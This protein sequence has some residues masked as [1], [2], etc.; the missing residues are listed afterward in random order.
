MNTN[1]KF[2]PNIIFFSLSRVSIENSNNFSP[3]MNWI[4][5]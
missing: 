1:V 4:I 2:T 5:V 3:E